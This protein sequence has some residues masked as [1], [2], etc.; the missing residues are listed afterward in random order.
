MMVLALLLALP[1]VAGAAGVP[2]V[3]SGGASHGSVKASLTKGSVKM[4]IT[5]L[6]TLPA[7]PPGATFTAYVYKTY[8]TSTADPAV[9][10]FLTDVYP[11]AKQSS[12][13]KVALKGDVSQLG[14]NRVVVTAY[15]KD[16]RESFDV[17]TAA[18]AP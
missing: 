8:L 17:L 7:V 5:G 14:L 12:S 16:A 15:S 13:N 6:P 1:L 3:D 9:E 11:S 2:F 4:K 18:I 10:I